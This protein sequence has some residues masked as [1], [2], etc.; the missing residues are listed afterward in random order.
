MLL[1]KILT[2]LTYI[3]SCTK[4]TGKYGTECYGLYGWRT[5]LN[6]IST[7]L[8]LPLTVFVP[9]VAISCL[10]FLLCWNFLPSRL[11][12]FPF[13]LLR[14]FKPNGYIQ[15]V[16]VHFFYCSF[17][18]LTL[19]YIPTLPFKHAPSIAQRLANSNT[20]LNS[21][22]FL[23]ACVLCSLFTSLSTEFRGKVGSTRASDWDS[24]GFKFGLETDDR[25]WYSSWSS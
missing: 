13:Q 18:F 6:K 21:I 12:V 2:W 24:P 1:P 11:S 23:S 14:P 22:L 20:K 5:V 3:P 19:L 17:C 8:E 4:E 10:Y 7:S 15:L 9:F 25:H 16:Y